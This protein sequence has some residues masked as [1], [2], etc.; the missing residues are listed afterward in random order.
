MVSETSNITSE[1]QEIFV[2]SSCIDVSDVLAGLMSQ[3][4]RWLISI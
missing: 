2:Y 4:S 3:Y 1:S